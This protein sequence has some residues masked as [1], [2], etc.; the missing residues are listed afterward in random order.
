MIKKLT[1]QGESLALIIDRS[2]W[3]LLG[4]DENTALE[5][6]TDGQALVIAPAHSK[7]RRK[8]IEGALADTNVRYSKALKRLAE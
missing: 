6:T 7:K 5:V 2:I 3:E 8:R 1:R 4:I